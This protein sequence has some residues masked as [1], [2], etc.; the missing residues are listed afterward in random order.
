MKQILWNLSPLLLNDD[1]P[2]LEK[3]KKAVERESRNFIRKWGKRSD[4]L[5][6]PSVLRQ[7]L[8]DYER[9]KR[10][11]G[12]DGDAG[13]YFWLRRSQ[14]QNNASLRAKFNTIDYFSRKIVNS[15]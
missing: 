3:K 7:A 2:T 12:P 6:N 1:D 10:L 9:W 14:D 13:Y 4:Y 8:D 5:K 11:Y 15:Q